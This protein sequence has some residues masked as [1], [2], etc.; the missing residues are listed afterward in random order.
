MSTIT[1]VTSA[2]TGEA[3]G[4]I[5]GQV[6]LKANSLEKGAVTVIPNVVGTTAYLRKTYLSDAIV[7]YSCSFESAGT[8]DLNEKEVKLKKL[9]LPLE[10]CKEEF[11]KRWSAHQMGFSAWNDEIPAD[12][13]EAII[14]EATNFILSAIEKDMWSGVGTANGHF[15]GIMTELLADAE[16]NKVNGAIVDVTNVIDAIGKVIDATPMDVLSHGD[17]KLVM[18]IKTHNL[19][20]RALGNSAFAQDPFYFEGYEITVLNGL[21][22]GSIL[23]YVKDQVVFL[24]GLE[25]DFNELRVLDMTDH[26]L[27]D[28]IRIKA[29]YIVGASY[30]DG[31]NIT[32]YVGA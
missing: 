8:L 16:S 23:T 3:A 30:V 25:S 21:P 1:N 2:Y 22:A 20:R 11:R 5:F 28:N 12:E 10:I 9:Q 13:K 6:F 24:T 4:K 17:F 7:D 29:Q 18:D 32:L 31:A 15:Q 26:D 19:Y 27:S 14:L